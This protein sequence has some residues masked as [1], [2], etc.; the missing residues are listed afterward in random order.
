MTETKENHSFPTRA[1]NIKQNPGKAHSSRLH[2]LKGGGSCETCV[3][4]SF[5]V[6]SPRTDQL[7]RICIF[8]LFLIRQF[9]GDQLLLLSACSPN[10]LDSETEVGSPKSMSVRGIANKSHILSLSLSLSI[11][12]DVVHTYVKVWL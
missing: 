7:R 1:Q 6:V 10:V 11:N 5:H 12:L 3:G 8:V 2:T 9:H 4:V